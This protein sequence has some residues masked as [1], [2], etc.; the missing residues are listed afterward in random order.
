M[1][2]ADY[3]GCRSRNA[4]ELFRASSSLP[5]FFGLWSGPSVGFREGTDCDGRLLAFGANLS[6]F[7]RSLQEPA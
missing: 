6:F 7:R 3:L 4:R 5:Q 1:P 2:R